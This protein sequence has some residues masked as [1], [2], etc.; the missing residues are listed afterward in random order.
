[1]K[2]SITFLILICSM[3]MVAQKPLDTIYANDQKN[4]ALFFPNSIRQ[5]ITGASHFV[6]TYNREK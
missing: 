5:G 6:F 2:T 1:M 4:V 3:A